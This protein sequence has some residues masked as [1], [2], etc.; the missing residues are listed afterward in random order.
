VGDAAQHTVSA[1]GDAVQSVQF[2]QPTGAISRPGSRLQA[3]PENGN[4]DSLLVVT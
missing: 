3:D 4:Y 1:F 2:P